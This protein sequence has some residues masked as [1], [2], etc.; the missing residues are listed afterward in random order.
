[1]EVED[2]VPEQGG[3]S[4]D[5]EGAGDG[6]ALAERRWLQGGLEATGDWGSQGG[7]WF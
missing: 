6:A 7:K 1:M 3:Q 2:E 4:R 5:G